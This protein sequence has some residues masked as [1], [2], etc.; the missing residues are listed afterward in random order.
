MH[1]LVA[2]A[3]VVLASCASQSAAP[4]P[5][6]DVATGQV[7]AWQAGPTLPTPRANHCSAVIGDWVLA[8]GGNYVPSGGSD[9]VKTDEIAAAQLG[10]DGTLGAWRVAGYTASPVTECN[11]TSDGDTLYIVDGLY[12]NAADGAQIWQGEFDATIGTVGPLTSTGALPAGQDVISSVATVRDDQLLLMDSLLPG[13][14]QQ[15]PRSRCARRAGARGGGRPTFGRSA[16][17]RRRST[18]SPITSRTRSAAT[19]R[20][21]RAAPIR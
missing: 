12:D 2:V 21:T 13:R 6:A 18:R 16:V 9:F 8:I 7:G 11:A 19:A 5:P 10:S 17:G 15:V 4:P 14:G 3:V 1:R 20:P